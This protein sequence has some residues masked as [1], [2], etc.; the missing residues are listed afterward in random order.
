MHLV[1]G[2][3]ACRLVLLLTALAFTAPANAVD[4]SQLWTGGSVTVKLSDNWRFSEELTTRFSDKRNGLYEIESN[5]LVGYS[6]G[7]GITFWAGYTHDPQ[8]AAGDFTIMEHRAREQV[9]FDNFATLGPGRL[10]GRIRLEQRWREGLDGTGWRVRPWLKYTLPFHQ[11]GKTALV[12]STEPFFDLNTTTF[13]RAR[14]LDRVRS[15]IGIS[16]PLA[17][18]LTME[19]GYLNQHI[20][21]R[22]GPD[23]DDHVASVALNLSL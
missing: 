7:Q 18:T 3:G 15:L 16:M 6:L 22:D 21:V 11:G 1:Q 13:Q 2:A 9:T 12:L 4:D 19:A 17:K 8:Y 23:E 5:T 14:G 10:N 20:F